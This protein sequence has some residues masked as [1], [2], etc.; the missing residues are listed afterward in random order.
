MFNLCSL[1]SVVERH[2]D[3]VRVKGSNPLD[4]TIF[5]TRVSPLATNEEKGNWITWGFESLRECQF[6][7]YCMRLCELTGF[8]KDPLY[9]LIK[10]K[11]IKNYLT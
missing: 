5:Y 10:F 3:T 6:Y 4:C 9:Q 8:K 2:L 11:Y 7:K 1:S